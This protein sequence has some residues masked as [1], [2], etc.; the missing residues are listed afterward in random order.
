MHWRSVN[1]QVTGSK[2]HPAEPETRKRPVAEQSTR[3][4]EHRS[5]QR[6]R[7][8]TPADGAQR[9]ESEVHGNQARQHDP[10]APSSSVLF[11]NPSQV[12]LV[13]M[14]VPDDGV[15]TSHSATEVR[16]QAHACN[17]TKVMR[18]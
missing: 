13:P 10:S 11:N 17:F 12:V 15:H 4:D 3:A 14:P 1:Q 6:P 2:G 16:G 5:Y 18:S 7:N 8:P 9:D